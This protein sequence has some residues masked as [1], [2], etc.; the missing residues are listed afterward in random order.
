M[1]ADLE[2]A[3]GADNVRLIGHRGSAGREE[4]RQAAPVV[5]FEMDSEMPIEDDEP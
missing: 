3:F 1:L 5:T 4:A 2:T